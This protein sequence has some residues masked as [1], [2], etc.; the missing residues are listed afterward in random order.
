M[1]KA[2]RTPS[3]DLRR[4]AVQVDRLRRRT[5]PKSLKFK[6]TAELEP[7]TSLVGQGRAM[8]AIRFGAGISQPSFNMFVLGSPGAGKTTAVRA[9]LEQEVAGE[10]APDDWIYVN[11]FD[12]PHRPRAIALPQERAGELSRAMI[13]AIDELRAAIPAMFENEE[14]QSRRHAIDERTHGSQE[15]AFASLNERAREQNIA[16]IRTPFG[17]AMAPSKDG[18]VIQ[19]EVFNQL[20]EDERKAIQEKIEALQG[21]LG[22][23]LK[24]I[25][26]LEKERRKRITE[27]NNE[28][29]EVAVDQALLEAKEAFADI[30]H[31]L[32]YLGTVKNDLIA[33]VSLFLGEGGDASEEIPH[34]ADTSRD[35]RFRRYMVNVVIGDSDGETVGAPLL[36]EDNPTL[37]NLVGRIEHLSQMGTLVTDFMLIKPGALHKANGGYLLLDARK[38]LLQPFAWEALKRALQSREITIESPAE[39]LSLISTVSLE[40]DRIPLRLKV[41][42][43]GDRLLYY[44]L[45]VLDPDFPGLFKVAADFDD[46]ADHTAENATLYARLVASIVERH[47]LRPVSAKGVARIIDEGTRMAGDSEKLSLEVE[48][49]AD[50]ICEAD[51]WSG[52]AGHKSIEAHDVQ[53]A[54]DESTFRLDR[55]REKSQE[56]ITRDIMLVDTE[57]SAIGQL[58]GLSV[59][60]LGKF[61]FG[62]PSRITARVRMGSGRLVDIEREVELGGPL[63]SKGVMILRGFLEGRYAHE[64]P[65]SLSASLVFEQSY[66][67][68]E[69]DSASSAELYTLLSA[70]AEIPLKQSIAVT[71][72]VNQHGKVQAIGGANEKIEGFFD[73]CNTRGLTGDQ[74][75]IIPRSNIVHLMLRDDVIDAVKRKKFVIYAVET[76]DEGIE[77]LTGLAAGAR[78][79]DGKFPEG[80]VNFLVENRL[81]AF[82]EAR[83]KFG[84]RGNTKDGGIGNSSETS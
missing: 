33:N 60:S 78:D 72:S 5:D 7:V 1:A 77:I 70:L 80:S 79:K 45:S 4:N 55:L 69:G 17:F 62:R 83:R 13:A 11:N 35:V 9:F 6:T 71:G 46:T 40:P 30:P 37:G 16:I 23:I 58:N 59:M 84:A 50:L 24:Q 66:G 3:T 82:A 57:G 38:V 56:S 27:L 31:V 54:V 29:A 68:V 15:D 47:G 42:L 12:A 44:M 75:V 25:P 14:Y 52:K 19:P 26:H 73:I 34:H 64:V 74:G 48:A 18:K 53:R 2:S 20:P 36:E 22:T 49:L 28:L 67:G 61:T 65:L 81:V 63:H 41:V 76:I 32:A 51:Y 43:F 8:A 39:Q 10:P 21:E